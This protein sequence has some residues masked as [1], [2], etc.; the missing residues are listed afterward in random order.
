MKREGYQ[1][2]W[3]TEEVSE[4]HCISCGHGLGSTPRKLSGALEPNSD[5]DVVVGWCCSNAR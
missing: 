1:C 3:T 2:D 4:V 5:G